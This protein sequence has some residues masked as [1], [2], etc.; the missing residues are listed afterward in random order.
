MNEIFDV[1]I[2]GAGPAGLSAAIYAR[3]AGLKMKL[4]EKNALAGGQVLNTYEV[5]NYPGI[6]DVSGYELGKKF[7]E[8]AKKLGLESEEAKVKSITLEDGLKHIETD[9]GTVKS[10]TVIIASGA[11]PR[12]LGVAGEQELF[13]MGVSYC[14]TCDGAFFKGRTVAVIG[15]GDVALEDAIFLARICEK[16]YLIHRR[17]SFRAAKILRDA[18]IKTENIEVIWDHTVSEIKGEDQVEQLVITNV[19]DQVERTLSLDGL[20]VAVGNVPNK[21]FSVDVECDEAGYI[22][23]GEDCATSVPGIYAAGD[24]RT[25][26]LRQIVTAVADG[27]NAI[28]GIN[29][30]LMSFY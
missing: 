28:T 5:D 8:H 19:K 1:V 20:F 25:K 7:L 4:I 27:A 10:K 3:R 13:G 24:I 16:V 17:D 14:A 23:A 15:G 18:V 6:P 30:Y 21:N 29:E 11:S 12:R 26:A 2:I 9:H 22:K